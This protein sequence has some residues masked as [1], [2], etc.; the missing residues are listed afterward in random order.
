[1]LGDNREAEALNMPELQAIANTIL[2]NTRQ[3]DLSEQSKLRSIQELVEIGPAASMSQRNE[4]LEILREAIVA[5][6]D[7]FVS[8]MVAVGAGALVEYGAN[9]MIAFQSVLQRTEHLLA[10]AVV[11]AGSAQM[12]GAFEA[13]DPNEVFQLVADRMPAQARQWQALDR[14]YM[15][16][17]SILSRSVEARAI[18]RQKTNLLA[19]AT[20][21]AP[22]H[23]G[24]AWLVR[25]LTVLD[26]ADL[27]ALAPYQA[28]GYR[29]RFSGIAEIVQLDV[30][31]ADV[32]IGDPDQGL[33]A[34]TPPAPSVVQAMTNVPT[35]APL[36][37]M[38]TFTF[39]QWHALGADG[40]LLPA[41]AREAHRL[42][43]ALTPAAIA[44][45]EGE[46]V[47]LLAPADASIVWEAQ[48]IFAGLDAQIELVEIL[49][50]D[51]YDEWIARI[52]E[53]S[54]SGD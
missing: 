34:G 17:I 47:V 22:I 37:A 32:L 36:A 29:V 30:L 52:V 24:A 53:A 45:L 27:I 35:E 41:E 15:A 51:A 40:R 8:A 20:Q 9:P 46:R 54:H 7:P 14:I 38:A 31:L 28:R 26:D 39:S 10:G 3:A 42:D 44:R 19:A 33:L 16:T 25:M 49:P 12:E 43:A 21:I 11:F 6:G 23:N 48:R 2:S 4:A 50:K 5:E 1:M 18:A 13:E